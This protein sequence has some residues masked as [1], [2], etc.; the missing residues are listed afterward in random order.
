MAKGKRERADGV[1][2]LVIYM[3]ASD[4]AEADSEERS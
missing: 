2:W 3:T 1:G 4:E